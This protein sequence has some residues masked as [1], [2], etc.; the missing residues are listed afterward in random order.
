MSNGHTAVNEFL[1]GKVRFADFFNG[2]LF[3][4]RQIVLPE[5]LEV[6]K[7]ESDI[8]V[9][10]K[11][12]KEKN[13]HRYRDIIMRWKKGTY[14]VLLACETQSQIHYAMPIRGMLYDSLSY[15]E[16]AKN[17]EETHQ[18][19]NQEKVSPGEYLSRFHKDD[20]LMPVVTVVF[21]YGT[22]KWDGS[23]D[24]Y[25]LFSDEEVLQDGILQKYVPNY[26]INLVNAESVEDIEYFRTDLK[27]IFGMMKYRNDKLGLL[28]FVR[29]NKEYFGSV[30]SQTY[31][32]IGELLQSK[33]IMNEEIKIKETEEKK[34]MC[35]ALDELY[36]DGVNEGIHRGIHQGIHQGIIK[37]ARKYHA[38]DDEIVSQLME[39]LQIDECKAKECLASVS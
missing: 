16:Q 36:Q 2:N 20:K 24:L 30:D 7:G 13:V 26:W 39:E 27:E 21:Y 25:G 35:K 19:K 9:E 23:T 6:V 32:V 5:D 14:L 28:N 29:E 31:R 37:T 3:Q 15:V 33:K 1:G 4:G 22:K 34:D 38:T 18:I 17:I 11:N 12:K 8:L 10:D